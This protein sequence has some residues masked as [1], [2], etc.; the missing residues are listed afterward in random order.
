MTG[1]ASV[2]PVEQ[3][4]DVFEVRGDVGVLELA[5]DHVHEGLHLLD[6]ACRDARLGRLQHD[7]RLLDHPAQVA[8]EALR[9]HHDA[10]QLPRGEPPVGRR[11]VEPHQLDV[12]GGAVED[13]IDVE[14]LPEPG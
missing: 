11:A 5:V 10:E 6:D 2:A 13:L 14:A 9:D 4:V 1:E 3:Q 12:L 7:V 8:L